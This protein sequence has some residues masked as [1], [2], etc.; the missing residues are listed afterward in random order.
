M[1]MDWY[2]VILLI[3]RSGLV[4]QN[5]V[6]VFYYDDIDLVL[7]MPIRFVIVISRETLIIAENRSLD[8]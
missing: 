4:E 1:I 3:S 2:I 8:L 6:E 7:I 5:A